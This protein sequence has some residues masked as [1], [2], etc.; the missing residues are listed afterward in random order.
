[1]R[2]GRAGGAQ[3]HVIRVQWIPKYQRLISTYTCA[4]GVCTQLWRGEC[5]GNSTPAGPL[6]Y[7]ELR[8]SPGAAG[9]A[10]MQRKLAG[11]KQARGTLRPH[12]VTGSRAELVQVRS[13][14]HRRCQ[15]RALCPVS[16]PMLPNCTTVNLTALTVSLGSSWP[17]WRRGQFHANVVLNEMV[18]MSRFFV[19]KVTALEPAWLTGCAPRFSWQ[20]PHC[21]HCAPDPTPAHS[22]SHRSISTM[23]NFLCG[24]F[25]P[26]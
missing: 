22:P 23:D 16:S 15:P 1:M 24:E 13:K 11:K 6:A 25:S 5:G 26:H 10:T 2:V 19:R 17:C 8:A 14:C 12:G 4:A 7:L 21:R 18:Q 20:R 3:R 9:M